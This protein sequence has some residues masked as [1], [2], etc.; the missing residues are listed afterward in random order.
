[1]PQSRRSRSTDSQLELEVNRQRACG[2]YG[3]RNVVHAV[4]PACFKFAGHTHAHMVRQP[5]QRTTL[6]STLAH[7]VPRPA[8]RLSSHWHC[9]SSCSSQ[10]SGRCHELCTM[11]TTTRSAHGQEH[12]PATSPSAC[13]SGEGLPASV[14][15]GSGGG[16]LKQSNLR[17]PQSAVLPVQERQVGPVGYSLDKGQKLLAEAGGDPS[18]PSSTKDW[19]GEGGEGCVMM[20]SFRALAV[21]L[22]VHGMGRIQCQCHPPMQVPRSR[23]PGAGEN[24]HT[25]L[26]C[27]LGILSDS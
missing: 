25:Q 4:V 23:G 18:G 22:P 24:A 13:C 6:S 12:S 5:E 10:S 14:T 8:L 11:A 9:H 3:A 20:V 16:T 7:G 2:Y 21:A 19:C 1:L 15:A 17:Q 26:Q 27:K